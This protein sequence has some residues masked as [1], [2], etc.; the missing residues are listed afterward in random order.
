MKTLLEELNGRFLFPSNKKKSLRT[1]EIERCHDDEVIR[2][3]VLEQSYS[4]DSV[5]SVPWCKWRWFLFLY[6]DMWRSEHWAVKSCPT[7]VLHTYYGL[8]VSCIIGSL[9]IFMCTAVRSCADEIYGN[10]P[11]SWYH[12]L[13]VVYLKACPKI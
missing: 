12:Q 5:W 7:C 8:S 4:C 3:P 9:G 10:N 11:F 6:H 13:D 2:Y 1:V